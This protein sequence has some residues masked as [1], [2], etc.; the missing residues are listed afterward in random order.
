MHICTAQLN[1]LTLFLQICKNSI[2]T[3]LLI[4]F[5]DSNGLA[6]ELSNNVSFVIFGHQKWDLEGGLIDTTFKF[7]F[8][9]YIKNCRPNIG[10][11]ES[12]TSPNF[13]YYI[14]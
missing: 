1:I 7:V 6:Q 5:A 8:G 2:F 4:F 13:T 9:M 3:N 11:L 14:I 12:A 10:L